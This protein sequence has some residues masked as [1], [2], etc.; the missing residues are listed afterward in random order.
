MRTTERN[1]SEVIL[2]LRLLLIM[3]LMLRNKF[4]RHPLLDFSESQLLNYEFHLKVSM[5]C[6][7]AFD[8]SK[9]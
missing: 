2:E 9:R 3:G 7:T 1:V 8:W 5:I 6:K 4:F